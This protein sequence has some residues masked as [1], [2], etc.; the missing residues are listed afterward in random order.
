MA[1]LRDVGLP[2]WS[3]AMAAAWISSWCVAA[4]SPNRP[5][6]SLSDSRHALRGSVGVS[7]MIPATR[8]G[9]AVRVTSG[10]GDE[11]PAGSCP[12]MVFKAIM[13]LSCRLSFLRVSVPLTWTVNVRQRNTNPSKCAPADR[14]S[15]PPL[16]RC[17]QQTASPAVQGCAMCSDGGVDVDASGVRTIGWPGWKCRPRCRPCAAA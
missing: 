2:P 7:T 3:T 11:A 4:R 10:A 5:S 12:T 8:S 6:T 13:A 15:G 17:C 16:L 1:R 9:T 14:A